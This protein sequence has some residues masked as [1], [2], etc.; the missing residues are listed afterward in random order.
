MIIMRV[1]RVPYVGLITRESKDAA[2]AINTT[3]VVV[4]LGIL[5]LLL[6]MIC[7]TA[8]SCCCFFVFSWVF[9]VP[10]VFRQPQL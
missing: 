7:G 1:K 4:V 8:F 10:R 6:P 3:A 5:L 9:F 2:T